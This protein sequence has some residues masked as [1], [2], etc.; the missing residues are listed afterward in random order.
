VN[1]DYCAAHTTVLPPLNNSLLPPMPVPC[2]EA[3]ARRLAIAKEQNRPAWSLPRGIAP[4]GEAPVSPEDLAAEA[5]YPF[6]GGWAV[7]VMGMHHDV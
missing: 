6:L 3:R 4:E 1:Q 7:E 5:I 2:A